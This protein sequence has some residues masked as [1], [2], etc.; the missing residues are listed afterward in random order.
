MRFLERARRSLLKRIRKRRRKRPYLTITVEQLEERMV[1][2]CG[3]LV[4]AICGTKWADLDGDGYRDPQDAGQAGVSVY[5]DANNN[6]QFDTGEPNAVTLADDPGTTTVDEAGTYTIS[7]LSAGAHKVSEVTPPGWQQTSPFTRGSGTGRLTFLEQIEDNVGGVDGLDEA[8]GVAVS[9]DGNH[10]YVAGYSDHALVVFDRDAATGQATFKQVIKDTSGALGLQGAQSVVVSPDGE[11]VYVA[12]YIGDA[13]AVFTRD[14]NTGTVTWVERHRDGFNGLNGLNGATSVAISHDGEHVYATGSID[15]A[16]VVFSRDD[17]TGQLTF[18]QVNWDSASVND[19]LNGAFS[20]AISPDDAHVYVG[21]LIDDTVGAFSRNAT[22]GELTFLEVERDG[23]GGVNG[24]NQASGVAVSPDGNHIY[25]AG[26][27]DDRIAVFSRNPATGL[28]TFVEAKYAG[29]TL[30][31]VVTVAVSPDGGH[32][33]STSTLSHRVGVFTRNATTGRLTTIET[34]I[35]GSGGEDGLAGAWWA[36]VSPDGENVYVVGSIDDALVTYDRNAGPVQVTSHSVLLGGGQA[37]SEIDFGNFNLFPSATSIVRADPDPTSAAA[38]DFTVTFSEPV[39]G[40]DA[41]DFAITAGG[42]SGAAVTSVTGSGSVYT[43]TVGTGTGDGTVRLDLDDND[44]IIDAE[45][46]PL[47]GSGEVNGDFTGGQTYTIDKTPPT[48]VSITRNES[49]PT[50]DSQLDFNVL[51]SENVT[52]VTLDDFVLTTTGLAGTSLVSVSGSGNSYTVRA[53]SGSGDGTL[54]LDLVDDDSII[55]LAGL[56]LGGAG[57]VNGD[58]SAGETYTVK[59]SVEIRGTVWTDLDGDG[60]WDAGEPARSGVTVFLDLNANDVLDGG[61]PSQVSLVDDPG[62]GGVDETGT[63]EFVGLA[64]GSYRMVAILTGDLQ[65]TYPNQGG[66]G[67]L[68]PYPARTTSTVFEL[69]GATDVVVSPDNKFVYVTGEIYDGL[70]VFSYNAISKQLLGVETFRD[71]LDGVEGLDGAAALT[72]DA[73]GEN[74][75]VAGRLGDELAVFSRNALTGE[76]TFMEAFTDGVGG[77]VGLDTPR[78][79]TVSPDGEHVYVSGS[80]LAVFDRNTST[81]ALTFASANTTTISAG[82]AVTASNDGSHVYVAD[83]GTN[84]LEVYSRNATTGAVTFVEQVQ[85][86]QNGV[87]GL[88]GVRD[89]VVSPDGLHLYAASWTDNAVAAFT[90]NASTGQLAFVETIK[91]GVD[92]I[93]TL[94]LSKGVAV[95]EDGSNVY[96]ASYGDNAVTVFHRN[97][98]DGKL[99][100]IQELRDGVNGANKIR[101]VYSIALSKNGVS[102]FTAAYLDDA[103]TPLDRDGG[104]PIPIHLQISVPAGQS[105]EETNFGLVDL[106]PDVVS[107]SRTQ[108]AL[109]NDATVDFQVTFNEPVTGVDASDFLLAI[110]GINGA[111][112]GGLVGSGADYTVTVNTGSGD[113]SI[114]L[115]LVDDDSILD[116]SGDPLGG[117]GQGNA[118]H[119]GEESYDIDKTIPQVVSVVRLDSTPT[120]AASVQFEVTFSEN[121]LNVDATDFALTTTQIG[122]AAI[123]NV[124]GFNQEKYTVTVNTGTGNGT[125]RLDVSDDD[126]IVDYAGN[127]LGGDG[128]NNGGFASGE[129]YQIEKVA[130]SVIQGVKWN[131]VNGN[132]VQDGAESGL[133]GWTLYLDQNVNGQFDAGEPTA[134]TDGSGAYTFTGLFSGSY[135]VAELPQAG[136]EQTFPVRED[137]GTTRVSVA[138]GG[139]QGNDWSDDPSIS[140]DGRYVAFESHASNLVT[141]NTGGG[142]DVYVYDRQTG[143]IEW[144]SIANSISTSF[145]P[146]ISGDGRYVAFY[147]YANNLV[148]GDTNNSPDVFVYDRQTQTVERVSVASDGTQAN[149]SSYFRLDITHDGR[150]VT[151]R[152]AATNLVAGDTNGE[153]DIFVHDRQ[154]GDTERVSV[155][156]AGVEGN[157]DAYDPKISADGRYVT[158]ESLAWNL[159]SGDTNGTNDVFVHDRQTGLTRRVSVSSTGVQGSSSSQN[160]D[161]SDDGR[162]VAFTSNA[163]NLVPGDTSGQA[164]VFVYDLQTNQI[165]RI[166][167][168]VD[169]SQGNGSALNTPSLSADGRFVAFGST[170]SNLVPGDINHSTDA[171]V[172]DRQLDTLRIAS[173]AA[174]GAA[175]DDNTLNFSLSSDGK[176]LAFA[177]DAANIV[178]ADSN[179]ERDVFVAPVSG[180]WIPAARIVQLG[181]D[182]TVS[183]VNLGNWQP[184]GSI[185]GE[186][187][188]D[189]D[190]DQLHDVN[191]VNLENWQIYIDSNGNQQFDGG[192]PTTLTAA[193]GSYSFTGLTADTYAVRE[194]LLA[195]WDQILPGGSGTY[196]LPVGVPVTKTFDFEDLAHAGESIGTGSYVH[197]GF[198]ISNSTA[199][200]DIWLVYGP[201]DS[202]NYAGST[203]LRSWNSTSTQWMEREEGGLFTVDSID[204]SRKG[205]TGTQTI[206]FVGLRDASLPITQSIAV[207]HDALQTYSLTGFTDIRRLEWSYGSSARHQF[208]NVV[209]QVTD[210]NPESVD[211]GNMIKTGEIHGTKWLDSDRDGVKD[212]GEPTLPGWTVFLD[213]NDNG[214]RDAGELADVTNANGDYSFLDIEPGTYKVAEQL[215]DGWV[216]TNPGLSLAPAAVASI[217]D[218]P[219]DG[220]GDVFN[221]NTGL[222]RQTA[223]S[224][225]RG[226][227]EFAVSSLAGAALEGAFFE[228]DIRVDDS[229][230]AAV[231]SFDV[232]SYTANGQPDLADFSVTG[233]PVGSIGYDI[234]N[235]PAHFRLDVLTALE[236]LLAA[237]GTHIGFRVDPTSADNF[238]S[239]LEN[240]KLVVWTDTTGAIS[241]S[242]DPDET[243]TAVDFG[244][245]PL[246][247]EIRGS[248]WH[249]LDGNGSRDA[250]EPALAG[251]TIYLDSN[252]NGQL[253]GGEPTTTTDANGDYSFSN[254][255]AGQYTVA[256]VAQSFWTQTYP[257]TPGGGPER[258]NV[259]S[260]EAQ[261]SLSRVAELSLSDDG[262]YV[263]FRAGDGGL[264]SGDTNRW[265]DVFVRDRLA[266]TTEKVSGGLAGAQSNQGAFAPSI[267]G[268]GRYVAFSSLASNLVSGDTNNQ[269][270]LFLHDRVSGTTE[271]VSV[272]SG[273]AQANGSSDHPI[274]SSDGRYVVFESWASNLVSGDTNGRGDIFVYDRTTGTTERVNT[275]AAGSQANDFSAGPSISADGRY[276]VFISKASNLVSG[277]ANGNYDVFVKDRQTGS[278]DRIVANRFSPDEGRFVDISG[279]GRFV[280]FSSAAN[281]LV[282]GD[283]NNDYDVFLFD[284]QT[285]QLERVTVGYDGSAANGNV[286]GISN[287]GR[288]VVFF[289]TANNI[290]RGDTNGQTDVF[291]FDRERSATQRLSVPLDGN[292]SNGHS[293][294]PAISGDGRHVAFHSHAFNLISGDTNQQYDVFAQSNPLSLVADS[295][296]FDLH[297][298]EVMSAV[299]FGNLLEN[300]LSV[301][302]APTSIAESGGAAAAIGT[303]RRN[304]TDLTNPVIVSLANS[305][306]S[307]ISIPTSVTILAGQATA[308]FDIDAVDDNL[309]DGPQ[310]A[311]ITAA[312]AGL[313]AGQGAIT[314]DDHETLTISLPVT[315]VT[316]A[317]GPNA[318]TGTVTRNNSDISAALTVFLASDDE[319]E[320]KVPASV[321]IP[322]GQTSADFS[323]EAV[324]ELLAD[325]DQVAQLTASSSGYVGDAIALTVQD[326]DLNVPVM[327]GP[328]GMTSDTTPTFTWN[329]VPDATS[330]ELWVYHANTQTHK[331]VYETGITGTSFTP[332]SALPAGSFQ[333]WLR[334]HAA[335]RKSPWSST[336]HFA[337]G[338]TLSAPTLTAPGGNTSDTT[339]TFSWNAVSNASTYELWVYSITA[340]THQIIHQTGLT[341]ASYTPTA[342][343]ALPAGEYRF[344][345]RAA[346]SAGNNGPWSASLAF[347]VGS[348]PDVPALIGPSG[349]SSDTTPTFSW[350]DVGA[351]RYVLWVTESASGQRVIFETN[352]TTNSFT[353]SA[354]LASGAHTFWVQAFNSAG[355]TNGWSARSD[356]TIGAVLPAPTILGP[357]GSTFDTTPTFT[358][359]AVATAVRY[360]LSVYNQTTSTHNVIHETNL[361][362]TSFTPAAMASG[363]YQ[364]WMR[365][366]SAAGLWGAW[367]VATNFSVGIPEIPAIIGPTGT[368]TDTTPTFSWNAT[369]GAARYELWV[370]NFTTGVHQVIHDTNITSTSYTSGIA[371]TAGHTYWFWVRAFNGDDL[372]G[373]WSDRSEFTI[374]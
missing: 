373:D 27:T 137:V 296:W 272:G 362:G 204:L 290:V 284:R 206:T 158:F 10:I 155:S 105:A 144:V 294:L 352:L 306:S 326:D 246:P 213:T 89:V 351:D 104:P 17:T 207:N 88:A 43:V 356:F 350:Q 354:A 160:A 370:Y 162:Y 22:T 331:I 276:V 363:R 252:N 32:V 337:I 113:G 192:E 45:S 48:T 368:T 271:R 154:T 14:I 203:T 53:G 117:S 323:V 278:I 258:I 221:T 142:T 91:D 374:L 247:A 343:E 202:T 288:M 139:T 199:T 73:N 274:L 62:T 287:D 68:T 41:S 120:N 115:D 127:T 172:Y 152:S 300:F 366:Q 372:A 315:T 316:E 54:R 36:T 15:D 266:G 239:V 360:E 92:G 244:N 79:V 39:T 103:V 253:D 293:S 167:L 110:N 322:S 161:I 347:S 29:T 263:T 319:S 163:T 49:N 151:F 198:V 261:T 184:R 59:K 359:N 121:V 25:V 181:I 229:G 334:A 1:L 335:G 313:A 123:T 112:I 196:S 241:I 57:A 70:M 66:L 336:G 234:G 214:T 174:S 3:G 78:S 230:G 307:E 325:G 245:W 9:P 224:E 72:M 217:Q 332:T 40:V 171:F 18:V 357:S 42:V 52:G 183:Q 4:D 170:S 289:S 364:Y 47:G 16:L 164:D 275:S 6:G 44:T 348:I 131:D 30:N 321:V 26:Y 177:S 28:M 251:W 13:V 8:A 324:D 61:E 38:V 262:R 128:V 63:Y 156:S 312:A 314:V 216:Q 87:D 111:S 333:F 135:A 189:R 345:V 106:D 361:T 122:D 280:V 77:V 219:P 267:S 295:Y 178:A 349:N 365:T 98:A 358:W 339:P 238:A 56:P 12:S 302:I 101:G 235:S 212:A 257:A 297:A 86:G 282:A 210:W 304:T 107:I 190:R 2:D 84:S 193:D 223:G 320:A 169:G 136:W 24:L 153:F 268:D 305:D 226:I 69:N 149:G 194:V 99:S 227:V 317:D 371:L 173:L 197:D 76:L 255:A 340:N 273:G 248:K 31:G 150:Y 118:N 102:A 96:V 175:A 342:G 237:S 346:D 100:L 310:I 187:W 83:A 126:S 85:D 259:S 46:Q 311:T 308:T 109:S 159:V 65:Q 327:I 71:G 37:V 222:L 279:D 215:T 185:S 286:P 292:E 209:V 176:F 285:S 205:W 7:G 369:A 108:P 129:V 211:F 134:I 191:E 228:F 11:H 81:G 291:V 355:Q 329:A 75:Y 80:D 344:W 124:T 301:E 283:N 264:V 260:S 60:V 188:K 58:F 233:T 157:N 208:D 146:A 147:S 309:L 97:D 200:S 180:V 19:G 256:E 50:A 341:A 138:T 90:R 34:H 143:S 165:E 82:Y 119:I 249:D 281:G 218:A 21:A 114:R 242:L 250:G 265:D 133:S 93:S 254:L 298:G 23:V 125:I 240:A 195:D 220:G 328:A 55:D 168:A 303:V 277:D 74:V 186:K 179:N 166:G 182:D 51:F 132:G 67:V 130:S 299:S 367:S 64:Q 94:S 145:D 5:V 232:A 270:D 201:Q 338:V 225:D 33:Y 140:A 95:S 148:A 269:L 353:P 318:L 231:R 20:I 330:Y 35:D 116:A 243:E 141:A 236:T